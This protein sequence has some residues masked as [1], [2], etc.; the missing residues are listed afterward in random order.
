MF[1][2]TETA[3]IFDENGKQVEK[4]VFIYPGMGAYIPA[5][6]SWVRKDGEI[7]FPTRLY[8]YAGGSVLL[9]WIYKDGTWKTDIGF[10]IVSWWCCS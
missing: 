7:D 5:E 4:H 8:S 10:S 2:R 3:F 9:P 1:K 6:D